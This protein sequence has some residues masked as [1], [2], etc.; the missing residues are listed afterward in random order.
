MLFVSLAI[1]P[2]ANATHDSG[3][4]LSQSARI[5]SIRH[6]IKLQR[7]QA[8]AYRDKMGAA[9]YPT[10]R[11]E[12]KFNSPSRLYRLFSLW[13]RRTHESRRSW[14]RWEKKQEA[15][16]AAAARAAFP[17]HYSA[18]LC[19]HS[20]ESHGSWSANTGNGY[21]GG[22]QMDIPFQTTYGAELYRLKGTA[23]HWTPMEQ[24]QVAEKAYSSG[25]GFGPWPKT[26][27]YCGLI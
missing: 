5:V 23:D 14:E 26:A 15:V 2:V 24:M 17:A 3:R 1:T 11:L 16:R 13:W 12:R 27:G 22:L 21:Y 10:R 7:E 6:G 9:R 19:I 18:W 4:K 8:Q 25:R 20:Y